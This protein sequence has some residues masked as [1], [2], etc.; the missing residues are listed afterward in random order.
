MSQQ[1]NAPAQKVSLPLVQARGAGP[2]VA[3]SHDRLKVLLLFLLLPLVASA[4]GQEVLLTLLLL[5]GLLFFV[6]IL[7]LTLPYAEKAILVVVY[8][9]TLCGAMFGTNQVPYQVNMTLINLVLGLAPVA[10]TV[11][12]YLV[13]RAR[14]TKQ[15]GPELKRTGN[16]SLWNQGSSGLQ[17]QAGSL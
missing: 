11:A 15:T 12:T 2:S 8:L 4:H 17:G 7:A 13:L 10:T 6:V 14:R 9:V 5:V 3:F 1:L 16:G